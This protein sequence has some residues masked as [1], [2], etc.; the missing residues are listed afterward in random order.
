MKLY[1]QMVYIIRLS[2]L[3]LVREIPL[4]IFIMVLR[5]KQGAVAG[6]HGSWVIDPHYD[7]Q[8]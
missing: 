7:D 2:K 3:L 4:R 6:K 5:T 8:G 1:H